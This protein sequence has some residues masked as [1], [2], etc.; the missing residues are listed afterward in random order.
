TF[1]ASMIRAWVER[2]LEPETI[3]EPLEAEGVVVSEM[4]EGRFLNQVVAGAHRLVMDEPT[5]VGG[6]DAGPNPYELL[7]AALGGCTSMTMRIYADHK[8]IPLERAE[9]EVRHAK[10]HCADCEASASGGTPKIDEWTR[11]LRLTGDLSA[12]Q[13]ADLVRIA[14]RC[15]VHLTLERSSRVVTEVADA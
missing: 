4:A 8:K 10:A 5:S 9:V 11:V 14:D 15:P 7:A 13:R 6:F 12:D 3:E 1:A 2:Y